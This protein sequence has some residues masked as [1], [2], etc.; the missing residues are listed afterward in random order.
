MPTFIEEATERTK[1]YIEAH[2]NG[3]IPLTETSIC[4][5]TLPG[6]EKKYV[7]KVR[8]NIRKDFI[9]LVATDSSWCST[10]SCFNT[11]EGAGLEFDE[12]VVVREDEGNR[13]QSH[14][15]IASPKCDLV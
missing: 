8:D 9:M 10:D 7:G 11:V 6:F 12:L 5:T 4:E 13:A 3:N 1:A 15:G 14:F 2:I